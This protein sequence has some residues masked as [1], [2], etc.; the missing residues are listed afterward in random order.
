MVRWVILPIFAR[1][2]LQIRILSRNSWVVAINVTNKDIK[3]MNVEP[4]PQA[5]KDLK[6]TAITIISMDIEHMNENPS[7]NGNQTSRQR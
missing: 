4:R 5:H 7:L 6:D 3:H 1:E 2:R